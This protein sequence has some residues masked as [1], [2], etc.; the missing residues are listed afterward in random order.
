MYKVRNIFHC[1]HVSIFVFSREDRTV[2][3]QLL[4]EGKGVQCDIYMGII[5]CPI[6]KIRH[7]QWT[8]C[9]NACFN[10]HKCFN[11]HGTGSAEPIMQCLRDDY[12]LGMQFTTKEGLLWTVLPIWSVV[13][14]DMYR[15]KCRD[16]EISKNWK[17]K[18]GLP[19]PDSKAFKVMLSISHRTTSV[20]ICYMIAQLLNSEELPIWRN[21]LPSNRD[22][23]VF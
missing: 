22:S 23:S 6:M 21:P 1:F 15:F 7:S 20:S 5:L 9:I 8:L 18:L 19:K 12:L 10:V 2:A 3:K 17:I 16:S 11:A 13:S 14:V 4:V